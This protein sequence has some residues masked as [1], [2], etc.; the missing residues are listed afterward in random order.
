M[1]AAWAPDRTALGSSIKVDIK[2]SELA[3]KPQSWSRLEKL[4]KC[5]LAPGGAAGST[6]ML[7]LLCFEAMPMLNL[8]PSL[9]N[10][11]G[12]HLLTYLL[13]PL[14]PQESSDVVAAGRG[15]H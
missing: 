10:V 13:G 1:I 6:F 7:L 4:P 5:N 3:T 14:S 8:Q 2:I 12:F 15:A 9:S 11:N